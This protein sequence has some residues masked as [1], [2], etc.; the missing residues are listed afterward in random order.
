MDTSH[1][2]LAELKELFA[3]LPKLIAQREKHEKVAARKALETFATERGFSLEELLGDAPVI[4][5]KPRTPVAAK[6]KNPETG[7]TWSGRGRSPVW[8]A[9][10]N[11]DDFKI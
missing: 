3:S 7:E 8:L 2:S 10:K 1:L 11:K 4:T 5:T 6:Y 9:G